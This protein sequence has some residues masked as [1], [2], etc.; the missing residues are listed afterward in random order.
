VIYPWQAYQFYD[1]IQ[2][3]FKHLY[4]ILFDDSLAAVMLTFQRQKQVIGY[5]SPERWGNAEGGKCH[6]IAINPSYIA[7][8][9]VI[10]YM[11]T[12][13]SVI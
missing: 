3:S 9:S 1:D 10:E 4:K 6:E 7:R 12:F 13:I 8:S 5:F 2:F 11:Q